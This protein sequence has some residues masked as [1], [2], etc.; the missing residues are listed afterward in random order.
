MGIKSLD[1]LLSEGVSGRGVLVRSDLNVPLDDDGTITD[2]GRIPASVPTLNALS[3]A[4]AKVVVTPPLGRPQG[5]PDPPF[6]P[7]PGA[8]PRGDNTGR[9]SPPPAALA[10]A[11]PRRTA[12]APR[13]PAATPVGLSRP[14]LT[15]ARERGRVRAALSGRCQGG[16]PRRGHGV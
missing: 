13:P 9:P 12:P 7:P 10:P 1:D 2:P 15:G 11:H 16:V 8:A 6:S 4:C 3:D 5:E 14:P